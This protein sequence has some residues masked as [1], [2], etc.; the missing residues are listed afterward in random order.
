[1]L[2]ETPVM[3]A[4][5]AAFDRVALEH[6]GSLLRFSAVLR[7]ADADQAYLAAHF[8]GFRI[9]PG[10][11]LLEMA[12]QAAVAVIAA[13]D[14]RF[15]CMTEAVSLRLVAPWLAEDEVRMDATI[16]RQDES[17]LMT[18][19]CR[20]SDDTVGA[21]LTISLSVPESRDA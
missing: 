14:N 21:R 20:R 9:F 16:R 15:V 2:T 4:P 11:F 8:P 10:V 19:V 1:M 18:G 13:Q 17:Y 5:L 3:A 6:D 12:N 7:P